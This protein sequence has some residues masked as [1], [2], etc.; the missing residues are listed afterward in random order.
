MSTPDINDASQ[1]NSTNKTKKKKNTFK[2]PSLRIHKTSVEKHDESVAAV[3]KKKDY[4]FATF[5]SLF[6]A[7]HF[8]FVPCDIPFKKDYFQ[9][10]LLYFKTFWSFFFFFFL[11]FFFVG[12]YF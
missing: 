12:S 11:P 7:V 2:F 1:D 5:T 8:H 10:E 9:I 3:K 6:Y 4:L